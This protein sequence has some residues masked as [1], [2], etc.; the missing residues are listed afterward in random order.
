MA[1]D[2]SLEIESRQMFLPIVSRHHLGGRLARHSVG[3]RLLV[4]EQAG[5]FNR[6]IKLAEF[7]RGRDGPSARK[8][9]RGTRRRQEQ[10]DKQNG[11]RRT[12]IERA[13]GDFSSRQWAERSPSWAP[14]G[15]GSTPV[16]RPLESVANLPL[17]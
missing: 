8:R 5:H 17:D 9:G 6:T 11:Q 3:E 4:G 10:N 14:G 7:D 16:T 12:A 15:K 13:D 1:G 2:K